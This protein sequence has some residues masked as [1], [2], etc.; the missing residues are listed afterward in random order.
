MANYHVRAGL[1]DENAYQVLFHVPVP[2]ANNAA[3]VSYRTALVASGIGGT[4]R[5]AEGVGGG[6]ISAAELAQVEA[7]EVLEVVEDIYTNPGESNAVLRARLDARYTELATV[8]G[9]LLR[10]LRNRLK[11][12][13]TDRTVS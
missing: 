8:N 13:G 6:L 12:W 10:G 11:Y 7:G 3:G 2:A 9:L 4:T 5:M 1:P